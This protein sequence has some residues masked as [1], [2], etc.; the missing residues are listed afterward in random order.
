M[1]LQQPPGFVSGISTSAEE[2]RRMFR[3][4]L[5]TTG[6]VVGAS[7]F[8]VAA[9]GSPNNT[10]SVAAGE[11][12]IPGSSQTYQGNYY[13]R[14]DAAA[15]VTIAANSSGN[16]RI[17][18]ICAQVTDTDYGQASTTWTLIDVQGTPASSPTVPNVPTSAIALAQI[19]VANGFSSI[20]NANITDVR[21]RLTVAQPSSPIIVGTG[22]AITN[23][24]PTTPPGQTIATV[25]IPNYGF[26]TVVQ[27]V[28][29]TAISGNSAG[30]ISAWNWFN[31]STPVGTQQGFTHPGV[32]SAIP[33]TDVAFVS[34]AANVGAKTYTVGM[35]ATG[36][37]VL[38]AGAGQCY[39]IVYPA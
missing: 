18:L 25:T 31:G 14:S 28:Y 39:G 5:G 3:S 8:L 12:W 17:D 2:A 38:S 7:D 26:A 24:N 4:I 20:T 1:T 32:G 10:V 21:K 27:L 23:T 29:V 9:Q 16:P 13:A 30:L 36:T 19:A 37:N 34:N 6:G 22:T 33:V 11:L 35:W 15:N